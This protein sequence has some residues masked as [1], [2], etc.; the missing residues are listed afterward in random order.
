MP[1]YVAG[2]D[3]LSTNERIFK[4]TDSDYMNKHSVVRTV[5]KCIHGE[6]RR[7]QLEKAFGKMNIDEVIMLGMVVEK[8]IETEVKART[9]SDE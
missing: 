9:Q 7:R 2:K 1:K 6:H 5:I 3:L 4:P 8:A